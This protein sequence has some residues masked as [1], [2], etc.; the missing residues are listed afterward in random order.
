MLAA[1]TPATLQ[2]GFAVIAVH[3][4]VIYLRLGGQIVTALG[5]VGRQ[6]KYAVFFQDNES[7]ADKRNEFMD[8][9]LRFLEANSDKIG[10]AGPL[11][12]SETD[13]PSGGLWLV[14][15]D[16]SAAVKKLI[17]ADPFW[18]TG[19]RKSVR[20]L[21]WNQVYRDGQRLIRR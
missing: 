5:H 15:A 20:V 7:H 21:E 17:E 3:I 14:E 6:M 11:K 4:R 9:H 18:P 12:D 2:A 10:A 1:L 16:S 19:L 8:D 13:S